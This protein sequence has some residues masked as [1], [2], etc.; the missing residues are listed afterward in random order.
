[1]ISPN[2][3]FFEFI[4]EIKDKDKHMIL[5]LA[6]SEEKQAEKMSEVK[7]YGHHYAEA[8]NG[9]IYFFRYHQKPYGVKEKDFELFRIVCENLIAKKQ[10]SSD[11][12]K[13][14]D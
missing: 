3:D 14:L 8:I 2:F 9:F 7:G 12:L 5:C 10:I 13:L 6:E 4:N 1:M 11:I